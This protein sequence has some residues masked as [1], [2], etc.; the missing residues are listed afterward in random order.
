MSAAERLAAALAAPIPGGV[1]E[2]PDDENVWTA[3]WALRADPHLAQ[4][5]EDGEALRRLREAL[6]EVSNLIIEGCYPRRETW[7]VSLTLPLS[8]HVGYHGPTIAEAADKAREA[9]TGGDQ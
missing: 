8:P 3:S 2:D 4:D 5:I 7:M 1:Y 6:P 9:L